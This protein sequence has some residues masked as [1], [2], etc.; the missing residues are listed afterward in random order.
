MLAARKN[1]EPASRA[2][3]LITTTKGPWGGTW[4]P[5]DPSAGASGRPLREGVSRKELRVTGYNFHSFQP[6]SKG[7]C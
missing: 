3:H 1:Y 7:W 4:P 5:W 2:L 6:K